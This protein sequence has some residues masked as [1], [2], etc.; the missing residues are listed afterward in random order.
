MVK[1][2][3]MSIT[4]RNCNMPCQACC[5]YGDSYR[6]VDDSWSIHGKLCK[7]HSMAWAIHRKHIFILSH[8][9][10]H[11]QNINIILTGIE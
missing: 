1:V 9:N 11:L 5:S 7:K 6:S 3:G 2:I 8:S 10:Q 4:L